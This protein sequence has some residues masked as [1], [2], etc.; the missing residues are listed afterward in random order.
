LS[1]DL[2]LLVLL[3]ALLHAGWNAW[4]RSGGDKLLDTT[5]MAIVAG[6]LA[7]AMLPLVAPPLAPSWPYLAASAAVHFAYFW[8]LAATYRLGELSYAYPIMRG[9]APLITAI[10]AAVLIREPLSTGGW[11][12]IALLSLGILTLTGDSLR[13]GRFH[14]G[15]ALFALANAA[16]IVAYTL[17]D[18]VGV[19]RSGSALSYILWLTFLNAFP[20]AAFSVLRT[21]HDLAARMRARWRVALLAAVCSMA[22][23]GIALWAMERA[24]I[25]LVAALRETSVIFGT[26]IAAVFLK[27]RFGA[28]RYAAAGMVSAGAIA[29]KVW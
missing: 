1:I 21:P 3:A 7:G 15:S 24:P 18:G 4:I 29:M 19:R 11:I 28:A 26:V 14:F 23:Y 6:A 20:L 25:A 5:S 22:S 2:M 27:E 13:R 10:A 8:L 9:S 12:G 16:T 17:I